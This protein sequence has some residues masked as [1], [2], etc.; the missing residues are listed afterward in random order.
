MTTRTRP[1]VHPTPEALLPIF[2][3]CFTRATIQQLLRTTAP[4]P[5]FYWRVFTPLILLWCLIVQRLQHDHTGDAV[6]SHLHTGAA[7]ALDPA[8][9][10][11]QPL[12]QRLRSESTSACR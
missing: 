1:C 2:R 7:D 6:V 3:T 12:S 10:H 5:C 4:N 8:D 9:P 11:L